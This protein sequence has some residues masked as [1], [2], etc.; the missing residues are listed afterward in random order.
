MPTS[1]NAVQQKLHHLCSRMFT[2]NN[3]TLLIEKSNSLG[4]EKGHQKRQRGGHRE[5]GEKERKL[6]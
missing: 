5:R 4:K 1:I 3:T 2:E 6:Y